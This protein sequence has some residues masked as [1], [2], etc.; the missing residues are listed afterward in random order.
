M[1]LLATALALSGDSEDRKG[2]TMI[3]IDF[4][5]N[6][7]GSLQ[8]R[9][10]VATLTRSIQMLRRTRQQIFQALLIQDLAFD[11]ASGLFGSFACPLIAC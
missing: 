9:L 4:S 1:V 2:W 8:S 3:H 10:I 5:Q 7:S 6:R 11:Q